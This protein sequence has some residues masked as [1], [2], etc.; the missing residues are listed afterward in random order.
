[1]GSEPGGIAITPN[2]KTA[3]VAN[4]TSGTVTVITLATRATKTIGGFTR[5]F[6]ITITPDGK[7]AWVT[8]QG[9]G[10]IRP[11]TVATNKAGGTLIVGAQPITV[12]CVP[13]SA[14]TTSKRS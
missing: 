13:P 4:I 9:A 3:Y 1:V 11:I 2:G 7:T 6:S 5:P 12:A 8:N 10:T 14:T